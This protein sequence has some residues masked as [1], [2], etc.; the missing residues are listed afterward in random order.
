MASSADMCT[1]L[2]CVPIVASIVR[3]SHTK[4]AF[5]QASPKCTLHLGAFLSSICAC[6]VIL[7]FNTVVR[8]LLIHKSRVYLNVET[9][10]TKHKNNVQSSLLLRLPMNA[11]KPTLNVMRTF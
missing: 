10:P 6:S 9:R 1:I 11:C 7:A 8:C 3:G 5:P 4:Q 2:V